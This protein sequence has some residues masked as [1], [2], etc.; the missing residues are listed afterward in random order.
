MVDQSSA[1]ASTIIKV[2]VYYHALKIGTEMQDYLIKLLLGPA[3]TSK[4]DFV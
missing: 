1:Y 2:K 4:K 3:F